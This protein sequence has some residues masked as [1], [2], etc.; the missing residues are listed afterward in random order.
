MVAK[1]W[2]GVD[3]ICGRER[4]VHGGYAQR[5]KFTHLYGGAEL[6][7]TPL[8]PSPQ[9]FEVEDLAVASPATVS[10]VGTIFMEPE[11]VVGTA[12]Q[13]DG[14]VLALDPTIQPYG[15]Q[16]GELLKQLLPGALSFVRKR[17][18][19]YVLTVDNNLVTSTLNVLSTFWTHF[20]PVQG[21]YEV[22]EEL[23]AALPKLLEKLVVFS[24]IWG[25]GASTDS[26]SRSKFDLYIRE[27]L[28]ELQINN[29]VGLPKDVLVYDVSIVLQERKWVGWMETIP[30]FTLSPKVAFEDI[31]VPTLDSVRYMWVLEQLVKD[32]RHVLAVG[33]TGTGKTLNVTNKL[34]T[35]MPDNYSQGAPPLRTPCMQILASA[36]WPANN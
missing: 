19:E 13:I 32:E 30:T 18:K 6:N 26:A 16:L 25:A 21:R 11:K 15:P 20:I 7:L 34:M 23:A 5:R 10:R 8:L 9:V 12:A 1:V 17:A 22:P 14:W 27:R 31:I 35:G 2:N 29:I 24:V 4:H 3:G 33:P 28:A 36:L